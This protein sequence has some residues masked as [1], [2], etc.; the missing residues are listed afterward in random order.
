M[1]HNDD[2]LAQ[3][4]LN[5]HTANVPD[6]YCSDIRDAFLAVLETLRR[7]VIALE[8]KVLDSKDE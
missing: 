5:I 6:T 2:D 3:L 8:E 4:L 7:R 1:A